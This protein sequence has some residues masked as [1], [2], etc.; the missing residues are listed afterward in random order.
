MNPGGGSI[1][2][3]GAGTFKSTDHGR[4]RSRG[5]RGRDLLHCAR[6]APA[7]P[8]REEADRLLVT[9]TGPQRAGRA[10]HAAPRRRPR[11]NPG[12]PHIARRVATAGRRGSQSSGPDSVS[13]GAGRLCTR[14]SECGCTVRDVLSPRQHFTAPS[15]RPTTD[16]A[17]PAIIEIRY[18]AAPPLLASLGLPERAPE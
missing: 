12:Q 13:R 2:Y 11:L 15:R 18:P 6:G 17:S 3:G 9:A 7:G 4:A 8:R 14:M 10:R 16:S 1:A 5:P